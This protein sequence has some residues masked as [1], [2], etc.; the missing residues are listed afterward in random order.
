MNGSPTK[1]APF[2]DRVALGE[3]AA[4]APVGETMS[5]PDGAIWS[6]DPDGDGV[7][8][9]VRCVFGHVWL[10]QAGHPDDVVLSPGGTC[11]LPAAGKVVVQALD[12]AQVRVELAETA[13]L[14]HTPA[15]RLRGL[16]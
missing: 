3:P 1:F 15:G 11:V 12:D 14:P 2:A 16:L 10:T 8:L 9:L 5:L 13:S 6:V 4:D 7:A